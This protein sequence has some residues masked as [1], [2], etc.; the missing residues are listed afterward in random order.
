[1]KY[2]VI[3]DSRETEHRKKKAMKTWGKGNVIVKK[4]EVGDYVYKN[5]G[6]EFKTVDDFIG[7]VKSKRMQ[8][9][10][11]SLNETFNRHY[12]IIY[13]D[14]SYTLQRLYRLGH[15]FTVKQYI[16]AV[17]SLSQITQVLHVDNESQAFQLC[18]SLFEKSTDGKNRFAKKPLT[19][20]GK[21]KNKIVAVLSFIGDINST[22]AEK[23][24]KELNIKTLEDLINLSEEDIMSVHGFGEKTAKNIKKWLKQ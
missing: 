9:Q 8:N 23:L 21:T 24:V 15:R 12:I 17:A 10:A 5:V 7:S 1:M 6:V 20:K 4:L 11:I 14:V 3:V 13:G 18:K 19:G 2:P 22:R 16:G